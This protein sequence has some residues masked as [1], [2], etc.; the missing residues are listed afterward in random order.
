[1]IVII[2]KAINM[3][4][5]ISVTVMNTG[6]DG[7]EIKEETHVREFMSR[8]RHVNPSELFLTLLSGGLEHWHVHQQ[9]H[10]PTHTCVPT[11][12]RVRIH[13]FA[14]GGFS[15]TL[16]MNKHTDR[17]EPKRWEPL[18]TGFVRH[19]YSAFIVLTSVSRFYVS[20]EEKDSMILDSP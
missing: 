10:T 16:H 19:W 8:C 20:E 7:T 13:I 1:M 11:S 9:Q 5:S 12:D 17:A 15:V 6:G 2:I 14:K 4:I 3:L 18:Q